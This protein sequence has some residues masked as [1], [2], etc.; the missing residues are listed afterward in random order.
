MTDEKFKKLAEAINTFNDRRMNAMYDELSNE[1]EEMI[2]DFCDGDEEKFH[3]LEKLLTEE[4]KKK[5][6]SIN[7][8]SWT[9]E[10]IDVAL[11]KI[12]DNNWQE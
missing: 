10:L 9:K 8:G 7:I 3:K 4:M 11:Q 2:L 12:Y 1:L 6:S 5:E